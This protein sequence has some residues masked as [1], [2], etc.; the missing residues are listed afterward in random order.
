MG[1]YVITASSGV[2]GAVD[3]FLAAHN[4]AKL[5]ETAWLV[6]IQGDPHAFFGMITAFLGHQGD[7]SMLAIAGKIWG[8]GQYRDSSIAWIAQ[9]SH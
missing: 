5:C 8:H 4:P 3:S 1:A 9:R 7:V 2:A 6:E